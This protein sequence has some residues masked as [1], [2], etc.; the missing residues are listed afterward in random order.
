MI[1]SNIFLQYSKLNTCSTYIILSSDKIRMPDTANAMTDTAS[2]RTNEK[3]QRYKYHPEAVTNTNMYDRFER[4]KEG[5][6]YELFRMPRFI[7]NVDLEDEI[8]TSKFTNQSNSWDFGPVVLTTQYSIFKQ[9]HMY[10]PWLHRIT[11]F[12]SPNKFTVYNK[13]S[14]YSS[15]YKFSSKDH[16]YNEA[17]KMYDQFARATLLKL[18]IHM[19]GFVCFDP[20]NSGCSYKASLLPP[21]PGPKSTQPS[22]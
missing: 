16:C 19:N 1:H 4:T 17:K 5:D 11:S 14:G 2:A 10:H 15:T 18:C 13:E 3:Y 8:C 20:S 12:I 21:V 7:S 9:Q 22:G 6:L